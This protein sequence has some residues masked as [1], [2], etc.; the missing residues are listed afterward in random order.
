MKIGRNIENQV[1]MIADGLLP[2]PFE[3]QR[4]T[5]EY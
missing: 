5:E 1:L 3:I 4:K 2:D